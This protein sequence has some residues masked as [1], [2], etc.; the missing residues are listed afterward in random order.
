MSEELKLCPFCGA[1]P[2]VHATPVF[3]GVVGFRIECEGACH[4]MTCWWHKREEAFEA[5]NKRV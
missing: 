2:L 5:W 1:I 3:H 4:A